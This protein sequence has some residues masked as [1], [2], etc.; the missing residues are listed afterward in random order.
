MANWKQLDLFRIIF[1]LICIKSYKKNRPFEPVSDFI[2]N[3]KLFNFPCFAAVE[4]I[5]HAFD[6]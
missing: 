5:F 1:N 3:R 6:I 4:Q 2:F